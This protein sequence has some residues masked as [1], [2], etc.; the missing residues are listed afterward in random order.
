MAIAGA[1][2]VGKMGVMAV[3]GPVFGLSMLAALRAGVYVAP[4]GEF[5]FVT[6]G[7]ASSAG[8]L[9]MAGPG[10]S[11]GATSSNTVRAEPIMRSHVIHHVSDPSLIEISS[12][13]GLV[14]KRRKSF[15]QSSEKSST[16][17]CK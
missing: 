13:P 12:V 14:S 8:L 11:C 2:L 15:D 3:V 10:Q 17:F 6:F 5:A 9:S 4:G 7:L 1:L 16:F